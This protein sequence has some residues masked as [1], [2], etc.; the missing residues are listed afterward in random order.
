MVAKLVASA[1]ESAPPLGDKR[2]HED[3]L[4]HQQRAA[5]QRHGVGPGGDAVEISA[6]R[7]DELEPTV[8]DLDRLDVSRFEYVSFHAPVPCSQSRKTRF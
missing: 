5:D 2:R 6:L 4:Q 1:A 8:R 3:R 7:F